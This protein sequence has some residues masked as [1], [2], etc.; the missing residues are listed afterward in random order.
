VATRAQKAGLGHVN[1][2]LEWVCWGDEED[3]LK[4]KFTS[5]ANSGRLTRGRRRRGDTL[6]SATSDGTA[7]AYK[8][9]RAEGEESDQDSDDASLSDCEWEG[10][11]RD[12][13]RQGQTQAA[14][15]TDDESHWHPTPSQ[16]L[17][18]QSSVD[19]L[20]YHAPAPTLSPPTASSPA[21][22]PSTAVDLLSTSQSVFGSPPSIEDGSTT[23]VVPTSSHLP[24]TS[25]ASA[26]PN[27]LDTRRRSS[28]VTASHINLLRKKDKGKQ[29]EMQSPH[30]EDGKT[31]SPANTKPLLKKKS[32]LSRPYLSL[33][34]SN[35]SPSGHEDPQLAT[36]TTVARNS[37]QTS[38]L[39]HARSMSN[40]QGSTPTANT[41][42]LLSRA[43]AENPSILANPEGG[44]KAG[45]V[46]GVSAQAERLF[47]KGWDSA[48]DFVDGRVGFGAGSFYG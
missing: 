16:P 21:S 32:I 40:I 35:H 29:K 48:V 10:W 5:A 27:R 23:P 47:V 45:F 17:S 11:M 19:S 6:K 37:S 13:D 33:T 25:T 9:I 46:K 44:R 36:T 4:S 42:P 22:S 38:G 28:T 12:L 26:E 31:D 20:H 24:A 43:A 30:N 15:H 14:R 39:R 8:S 41:E 7:V 34:F 1:P 18:T 3:P 2:G